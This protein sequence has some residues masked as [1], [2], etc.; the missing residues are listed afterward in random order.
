M[1]RHVGEYMRGMSVLLSDVAI[2]VMVLMLFAL[3]WGW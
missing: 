1:M 2:A 3:A